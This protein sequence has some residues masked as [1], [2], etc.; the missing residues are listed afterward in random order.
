[1][2]VVT[3]QESLDST[4]ATA[5]IQEVLTDNEREQAESPVEHVN[6][7]F[8]RM[9]ELY[10][11]RLV[12]RYEREGYDGKEYDDVAVTTLTKSGEEADS[13]FFRSVVTCTD[14]SDGPRQELATLISITTPEGVKQVR[15]RAWQGHEELLAQFRPHGDDQ[16]HK[17]HDIDVGDVLK[18]ISERTAM[19]EAVHQ[20]RTE[21]QKQVADQKALDVMYE[22]YGMQPLND[23]N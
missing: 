12:G 4:I 2:T 7:E 8:N 15:T 10:P 23:A 13:L 9:L 20:D 6:Q 21:A 19:A 5:Q 1:M 16:W 18:E 3:T 14:L 17:I 22:K 11:D